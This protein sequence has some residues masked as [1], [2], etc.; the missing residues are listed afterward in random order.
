MYFDVIPPRN[1]EIWKFYDSGDM[2]TLKKSPSV[3]FDDGCYLQDLP[4]LFLPYEEE[5]RMQESEMPYCK[6]QFIYR[7][8]LLVFEKFELLSQASINSLSTALAHTF[9]QLNQSSPQYV[10]WRLSMN[11]VN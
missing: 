8:R 9:L 3:Y 7:I 4:E 6:I 10:V 11:W 5:K 2:R 1:K